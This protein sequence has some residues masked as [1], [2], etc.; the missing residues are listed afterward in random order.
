MNAAPAAA[1]VHPIH[2]PRQVAAFILSILSIL[3]MTEL[4]R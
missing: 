4:G 3:S 1:L 2:W